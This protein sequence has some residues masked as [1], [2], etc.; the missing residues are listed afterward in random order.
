MSIA[1]GLSQLDVEFDDN[2]RAKVLFGHR[3]QNLKAAEK[4]LGIRI[5]PRGNRL[6]LMGP[7]SAV[8]LARKLFEVNG[9]RFGGIDR[10]DADFAGIES[11]C[12]LIDDP[13]TAG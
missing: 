10:L 7:E 2:E 4:V 13:H 11:R 5:A 3:D 1:P 9:M 6:Q 8:E 12:L